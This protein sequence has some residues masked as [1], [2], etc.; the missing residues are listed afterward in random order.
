VRER[1]MERESVCEGEWE[2]E[3]RGRDEG[4]VQGVC[5]RE[6]GRD[7]ESMSWCVLGRVREMEREK[8]DE[9]NIKSTER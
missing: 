9:A 3:L 1:K 4:G 7:A 5:V 6:S 8:D 2:R